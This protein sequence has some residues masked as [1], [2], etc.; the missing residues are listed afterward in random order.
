MILICSFLPEKMILFD[1]Y[2]LIGLKSITSILLCIQILIQ[3]K[4]PFISESQHSEPYM[5]AMGVISSKKLR[6]AVIENEFG[7]VPIDNELLV[8]SATWLNDTTCFVHPKTY[9]PEV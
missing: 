4:F 3:Q 7:A 6:F 8:N 9:P 2:F 5:N 1:E